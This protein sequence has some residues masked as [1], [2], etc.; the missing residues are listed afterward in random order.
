MAR[1]ST[2]ELKGIHDGEDIWI[3]ASG[4]SAGFIDPGFFDGKI[5]IGVNRVWTRFRTQYLVIKELA[6]LKDAIETGAQV[7]ASN[8]NCGVL[9]YAR[10]K[11]K[12]NGR[13]Y[14]YF[15][16]VNNETENVNLD[17]IGTDRIV[18][19]FSTITSAMHLAAYMGA[20]NIILVGHDCGTIDGQVNYEGY[21]ESLSKS[22]TFYREFLSR[23]EP[24]SRMVKARL[25]EIYGCRIYSINPWINFGLEDH[26][27]V[28]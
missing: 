1:I 18:V 2:I 13:D 25:A 24:Q 17:V 7:I 8:H 12:A 11:A 16:H 9:S 14:Y 6:I 28:S 26:D 4:P 19:S 23:I 3:I 22:E 15:E 21:P 10:N 27:Y 5:T 20:S